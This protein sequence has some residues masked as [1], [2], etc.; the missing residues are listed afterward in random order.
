MASN[1]TICIEEDDSISK[2]TADNLISQLK[3]ES[4]I[5]LFRLINKARDIKKASD[6]EDDRR[7]VTDFGK[8]PFD[9]D[10][11]INFGSDRFWDEIPRSLYKAG[12][13][14]AWNRL[15]AK[16]LLKNELK[17]ERISPIGSESIES[18]IGLVSWKNR[19]LLVYG[20]LIGVLGIGYAFMGQN[21][22]YLLKEDPM[23][24]AGLIFGITGLAMAIF[25]I[26]RPWKK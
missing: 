24:L 5:P 18:K 7:G 16:L 14:S 23:R 15:S 4:N 10:V 6:I 12:L 9:R 25:T 26:T 1:A 17:S 22:L 8:I 20:I 21:T 2:I 3:A 11:M 19:V 13:V